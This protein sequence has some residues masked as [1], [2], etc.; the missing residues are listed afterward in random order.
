MFMRKEFTDS[1]T[2]CKRVGETVFVPFD[3][4]APDEL[5]RDVRSTLD[6]WCLKYGVEAGIKEET[7]EG[8]LILIAHIKSGSPQRSRTPRPWFLMDVGQEKF[9]AAKDIP[10]SSVR[11]YV[12]LFCAK[13]G[14]AITVTR[15]KSG[16]AIKRTR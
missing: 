15:T 4:V 13:L 3:G 9:I 6:A 14:Q 12:S 2:G 16:C 10:V 8:F 11:A 7:E 1:L 5:R